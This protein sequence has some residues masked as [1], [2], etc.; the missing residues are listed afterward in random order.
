MAL[1][2]LN[3]RSHFINVDSIEINEV[4]AGRYTV[5][6]DG[7]RSFTVIGGRKA[8]GYSHEWFCHHPLFYGD[9][10]MPTKSMI[11]AIRLG[12]QY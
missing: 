8:G 5:T 6:Y 7:D 9:R 2:K 3:G 11:E 10:Y 4:S 12:A 1:L